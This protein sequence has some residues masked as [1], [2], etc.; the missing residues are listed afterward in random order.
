MFRKI[1]RDRL[2]ELPTEESRGFVIVPADSKT[3]DG[4]MLISCLE[5]ILISA[6][7]NW[8]RLKDSRLVAPR[9]QIGRPNL[10]RKCRFRGWD[11]PRFQEIMKSSVADLLMNL[12]GALA[13]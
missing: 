2:E 3:S 12:W 8:Q 4:A 7:P 9:L 13:A 10:A 6:V 5:G 11:S 1:W